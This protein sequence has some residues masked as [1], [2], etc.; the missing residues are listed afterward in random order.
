MT[1]QARSHSRRVDG[2]GPKPGSA[3]L[4]E[5]DEHDEVSFRP[6][7]PVRS[8]E[9]IVEQIEEAIV[10]GRLR[11][12]DFLPSERE[13]MSQFSVSRSTVREAMR[14]LESSGLVRSRPGNPNG[15]EV[16]GLSTVAL[17]K[18]VDR[19]VTG[20]RI[21]L[22]HLIHFRM[23]MESSANM[24]AA[25]LRT[26]E[27]LAAMKAALEEM[28]VAMPRGHEAFCAADVRFHGLV[29][30]VSGNALIQMFSEV[31][32]DVVLG[33]I[34]PAI[35]GSQQGASMMELS[36]L[37]HADA[38]EAIRAKDAPRAGRIARE[39]LFEHFGALLPPEDCTA[40]RL[41]LDACAHG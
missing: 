39:N 30:Q 28:R 14:V 29:A 19:L 12:G 23:L 27:D 7:R 16:L 36:L 40:V 11:E 10:E 32:H 35:A 20:R 3:T 1:G 15:A 38:L 8:Y 4:E 33:M 41:L 17:R 26:S 25:R 24:L 2:S 5:H 22:V 21:R 9:R 13:M 34:S 6:I 37:H 31:V 18:T